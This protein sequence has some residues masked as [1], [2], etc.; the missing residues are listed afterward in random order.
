MKVEG[1]SS[2]CDEKLT[3][4][5]LEGKIRTADKFVLLPMT[6]WLGDIGFIFPLVA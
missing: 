2:F 5:K 4:K 3:V 6:I 1:R